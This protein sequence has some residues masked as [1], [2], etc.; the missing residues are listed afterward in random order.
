MRNF[1]YTWLE[2]LFCDRWQWVRK[3]SKQFWVKDKKEA[4]ALWVKFTNKELDWYKEH[5]VDFNHPD[6]IIEDWR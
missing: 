2:L 6:C 4:G 3:K 1:K 5:G